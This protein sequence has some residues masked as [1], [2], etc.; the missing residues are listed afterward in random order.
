[1]AHN[2]NP[3]Y[4]TTKEE[5]TMLH[6]NGNGGCDVPTSSGDTLEKDAD[7]A[8]SSG[9]T[10]KKQVAA[11][12]LRIDKHK[13]R[14]ALQQIL[15]ARQQRIYEQQCEIEQLRRR[16]REVCNDNK[17][18]REQN[19]WQAKALEKLDGKHAE[20]PQLINGHLEEIR[21]FRE[22]IRRMKEVLKVEKQRR[23]DAEGANEKA[24]FELRHLR[25][26]AEEQNLLEREDL[27]RTIDKLQSET[28]ERGR[29][30]LNL[31]RYAENLEKNQRFESLRAART[32]REMRDTCQRLLDRIQEL[33]QTVQEKQKLIELGNIYSKRTLRT[34]S[35]GQA[36][37]VGLGVPDV[38][39]GH[40]DTAV[41]ECEQN[42]G[43]LRERI[44]E[45]EQ[46]RLDMER[47]KDKARKK[48][49]QQ[50]TPGRPFEE[51][52][53]YEPSPEELE[54]N[55]KSQGI[56]AHE[57]RL[58]CSNSHFEEN[59]VQGPT[60]TEQ[61]TKSHAN[62][63][64]VVLPKIH[65]TESVPRQ[66]GSLKRTRIP[67]ESKQVHFSSTN[68]ASAQTSEKELIFQ[69]L[70]SNER[71]AR[72]FVEA[73][74]EREN[75]LQATK[76]KDHNKL[77]DGVFTNS[78][79]MLRLRQPDRPVHSSTADENSGIK[80]KGIRQATSNRG[81]VTA[82]DGTEPKDTRVQSE[83]SISQ[84]MEPI[85]LEEV[86]SEDAKSEETVT[87]VYQADEVVQPVQSVQIHA[88]SSTAPL[89]LNSPKLPRSTSDLSTLD[90]FEMVP[91][92]NKTRQICRPCGDQDIDAFLTETSESSPT[93]SDTMATR[94]EE[95]FIWQETPT[96]QTSSSLGSPRITSR[97][98][99]GPTGLLVNATNDL[100][101]LDIEYITEAT[102]GY[103][104][105]KTVESESSLATKNNLPLLGTSAG[106]KT[107]YTMIS[108]NSANPG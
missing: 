5:R 85:K 12:A 17:F 82:V 63:N 67:R 90:T 78:E 93:S 40:T 86:Y 61:S 28:N 75:S 101:S 24:L 81:P 39:S 35:S 44:K 38:N 56:Q 59:F 88:P 37:E 16:I 91:V 74:L 45:F 73:T 94:G 22:Q 51:D 69:E 15:S 31:E 23:H 9:I 72:L 41:S 30:L 11:Y 43:K 53:E 97:L 71:F 50:N 92:P 80:T 76:Q 103:G 13:K 14:Q 62:Q 8:G 27:T 66:P 21:V 107:L 52:E 77:P 87:A 108:N 19:Y 46:R 49:L 4:C 2:S 102:L 79:L 65:A 47:K 25:K 60:E 18:L 106:T 42:K 6:P 7:A 105:N 99:R 96:V 57:D 36:N 70:Q 54:V 26:L 95:D 98:Y 64:L 32:Q 104:P 29:L 10:P 68:F 58:T 84:L 33:E 34:Q 83:K 89:L 55:E 20:L 1:M 3:F 100:D 48:R